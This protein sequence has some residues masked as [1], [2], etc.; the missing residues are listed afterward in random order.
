MNTLPSL[1]TRLPSG[2][3]ELTDSK[4]MLINLGQPIETA[5]RNKLT[6]LLNHVTKTTV[7]KKLRN[8]LDLPIENSIGKILQIRL[9]QPTKM[10]VGN[11]PKIKLDQSS[12]S[13]SVNKHKIKLDRPTEKTAR[14]ILEVR[15]NQSPKTFEAKLQRRTY[16]QT[17]ST[18]QKELLHTLY[19]FQKQGHL[20][21]I[22]VVSSDGEAIVAHA[23][24]LAAASS[25]LKQQL[26]ECHR[27]HY[28]I[29]TSFSNHTLHTFIHYAY[30][31]D[32]HHSLFSTFNNMGLS[33]HVSHADVM[34]SRLHQFANRGLYCNMSLHSPQGDIRPAHSYL[35]AAKYPI[36][37]QLFIRQGMIHVHLG[38]S[39]DK[40]CSGLHNR[41]K[42][43]DL[44]YVSAN[45]NESRGN[46]DDLLKSSCEKTADTGSTR[47][48]ILSARPILLDK[49][50]CIEKLC[51]TKSSPINSTDTK[52]FMCETRK[53][54]AE[55]GPLDS[56]D[57]S[58][59]CPTCGKLFRHKHNLRKHKQIH[60][61]GRPYVCDI[62]NKGFRQQSV[63]RTHI[64]SHMN[65]T[66]H[67]CH[68]CNR[69]LTSEL[70]LQR[71]I[72]LAHT[73]ENSRRS[74]IYSCEIC[75]REF[76]HKQN[77][78]NHKAIHLD[79]K[80]HA[81]VICCKSFKRKSTL[82]MHKLT[83]EHVKPHICQTCGKSF[84]TTRGLKNHNLTHSDTVQEPEHI[85]DTC[86]KVFTSE[87]S[88]KQ[89]KLIHTNDKSHVCETCG[90]AF[91]RKSGLIRH[92]QSMHTSGKKYLCDTCGKCFTQKTNLVRHVIRHQNEQPF[93]CATCGK[94][95]ACKA[96]L[97][98]HEPTHLDPKKLELTQE[99][100][101]LVMCPV[102][103]KVFA[104][105]GDLNRHLISHSSDRHVEC[106]ICS[107]RYKHK[108]DLRRH[109]LRSHQ[110]N[111]I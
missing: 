86:G 9:D 67:V 64:K 48:L 20:C 97:T 22:T 30:T 111:N 92:Q 66:S 1:C 71:H 73:N 7:V 108:D 101:Q 99:N 8:E 68:I 80:P 96:A 21:D 57:Q 24:V 37:S 59:P 53:Q 81:C 52:P 54:S 23:G 79:T 32:V 28:R 36:L 91:L 2:N 65:K 87:N 61:T 35:I 77:L 15:R 90:K 76:R 105:R 3:T 74:K 104:R 107:K 89:H 72:K 39:V 14:E 85:C 50:G 93:V 102:C 42:I 88:F 58:Y 13:N 95:Y 27:G 44:F 34:M 110:S 109:Q 60:V 43:P 56:D 55:C 18:R 83:H 4:T 16:P 29:V 19:R 25:V 69:V 46:E 51:H 75:N 12:K 26:Q 78:T 103:D 38:K 100:C 106:E 47:E 98:R 70:F 41:I 5:D 94:G 31:G 33:C 49:K 63:L 40:Y 10:T 11:I 17:K 6:S 82:Y 62:C 45:S 84:T